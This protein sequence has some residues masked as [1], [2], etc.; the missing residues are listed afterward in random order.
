MADNS[1]L[2]VKTNVPQKGLVT[3]LLENTVPGELW[4]YARNVTLNSQ[5]GQIGFMQ[6]EPS[7]ILCAEVPY[8]PIGFIRLLSDRWA[9][10]STDESNSEIGIFDSKNCSYTKLVNDSCLGFSKFYPIQGSSKELSDCTEA[11][12]WTDKKNPRRYLKLAQVPYKYTLDTD[13]CQ[14][15]LFTNELDCDAL[16]IDKH[17]S[18]PLINPTLGPGGNLKNGTYEFAIAYTINRER[19][20]DFYGMTNP[21]PIWSHQNYGQ[22]INLNIA[23]LDTQ[24]AE[25]QLIVAYE[26]DLVVRYKSLGYFPIAT[27]QH[28]VSTTDR[29]EYTE[30]S[31]DEIIVK[32]PKYPYADGVTSNDQYLLWYGMTSTPE[33]NYQLQAMGILS[34]YVVYQAPADYYAKGGSIVGNCRDENMAFGIQWLLPTGEWSSAFHIP[35]PKPSANDLGLA[36]GPNVYEADLDP[37]AVVRNWQVTN[38][39]GPLVKSKLSDPQ[40]LGEGTVGVYL[41]AETYPDNRTMFG[42]DACTPIRHH[43]MPDS[44][45]VHI[46]ANSGQ[47]INI[48]GMRFE[49]IE[50]PKDAQGKYI[51]GIT[52]YRI[53]RA[54]R[55]GNKTVIANGL[56]S[57]VRAYN[58]TNREVMYANYGYNDL[59]ADSFLGTKQV[60]NGDGGYVPLTKYYNSRFNFYGPHTQFN[61][62]GLGT[63]IQF[64]TEEIAQVEGFFEYAYRHP[65][66]KL[67][68][69]FDMYFALIIG[70]LDGYYAA[71]G[72]RGVVT[73]H[74]NNSQ[75][76]IELGTGVLTTPSGPVT[77]TP[78]SIAVTNAQTTSAVNDALQ[79][80]SGTSVGGGGVTGTASSFG[81]RVIRAL[82]EVGVFAYFALQTA[83]RV[84]DIISEASPYQQYAMQYNSHG[85]FNDYRNV[86]VDNRRRY[87]PFYQYLFDGLNTVEDQVFNNFKR[88]NSVYLRIAKDIDEP[89][90]IDN[91]RKTLV[92]FGLC[93]NPLAQVNSTASMFYVGIKRNNPNQYGAID[94]V[95]Y[96]DTGYLD[97]TLLNQAAVGS[98]EMQYATGPVFGGDTY[99]NRMTTRRS[100]HFFSTFLHDVADTFIIDYRLYR[101]VAYP[102]YWINSTPYDM[103]EFVSLNPTKSHTPASHHNL[104]CEG[105][106]GFGSIT[107]VKDQFFYLFNSGVIDF[108]CESDYNLDYRDWTTDFPTFY[109]RFN[110]DLSSIFRT[111]RIELREEYKYDLSYSKLLTEN[112]IVQ[113]RVDYNPTTD[114]TCFQYVKNR[115]VYSLPAFKD[116]RADNWLVYLAENYWDFP[117]TEFGA[118]TAVHPID[119]QQLMFLFDK[120]GPYVSIGRDELQLDGSGK[121]ITLGDGGLFS[122][123]PR[124]IAF[125]DYYY[126][127]CQSRWAFVNTPFGSYYPSERQGNLFKYFPIAYRNPITEVTAG[128]MD[129][130]F[131]QYLPSNLEV[132]FPNYKHLDKPSLG[133][134]IVSAF[135]GSSGVYYLTKRDYRLKDVY[136]DRVTYDPTT[137]R[138]KVDGHNGP[139]LGDPEYFEDASWTVSYDARSG[140]FISWHD[141]HPEWMLQ[142][143]KHFIT[144]KGLGLWKH[145]ENCTSFCNFYG[146]DYPFE[147]EFVVNN[148]QNVEILKSIEYQMEIGQYYS[149]CRNFHT[150][151]DDNFDY[152][153]VYNT[154]QCSGLLHL[155]LQSK[156]DMAQLLGYPY[157]NP[158]L[159]GMEILYAKEEQ[160]HRINMFSDLINDRGEFDKKN[161]PIWLTD[162]NGY[163]RTMPPVTINYSKPVQLQKKFRSTW[164]KIF[165]S[166][167]KSG[168][169]KY[170]FKFLNG[171]ENY[172]PR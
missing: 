91:T 67:L 3:D 108:F 46:H 60:S 55:R 23:G 26:I 90:T 12:Y 159:Q 168:N 135:D 139:T 63:E 114:S 136:V 50:H 86:P 85:F 18:L 5:I 160:K 48:L 69:Q 104:N 87:L 134:A 103:S 97:T 80:V 132:Q 113:Q 95:Q 76:S 153:I 83:N 11:I 111:D 117:M 92:E 66:A 71:S 88:E 157:F 121:K 14:T 126:A 34:R 37:K 89:V 56:V 163:T 52:A 145:N 137:D 156:K 51:T 53:V 130:W 93:K 2:D 166:K 115:V 138:F 6:N 172:S 143:E 170:I 8:P 146:S 28:N 75:T 82:A 22:S 7:N 106:S 59:R 29:P 57:N 144:A 151:L 102:R 141:W 99:I 70:A 105:N 40:V 149:D 131:N 68:T 61:H 58:E 9:V 96:L 44:T 41:S 128:V 4:T 124:P 73:T 77:A 122:R 148:G 84:L 119:N 74:V 133:T 100:H 32:R 1:P 62:I 154:E 81:E 15:K 162:A 94:S 10:F 107:V 54:D 36:S 33:L 64:Y 78:G 127:N 98:K 147:V 31:L 150:V 158:G 45:K 125:S 109:S 171:K 39:A 43:R 17:F 140:Q 35:G 161:F 164:H 21:Q 101:N 65:K 19:V 167:S 155:N 169:R 110:S 120:A 72:K 38:T 27:T 118:L 24:F 165:L 25:Y 42:D 49:N 13:A 129:Y 79:F 16:L 123:P 47:S 152:L 116:Q 20:T 112:Y 142:T 30:L